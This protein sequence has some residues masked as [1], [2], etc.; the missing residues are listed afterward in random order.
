MARKGRTDGFANADVAFLHIPSKTLIQADL[1]FN[2]PAT[3]QY[4]QRKTS[5]RG[6]VP[7]YLVNSWNP[8]GGLHKTLVNGPL[9]ADK[10]KMARSA[11]IV[12]GWDFDRYA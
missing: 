2:L 12:A 8:Y 9:A 3:E 1:L 6:W 5:G 10:S 4:S 11:K 7:G